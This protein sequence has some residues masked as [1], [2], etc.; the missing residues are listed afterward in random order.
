MRQ[1]RSTLDTE[2]SAF[3]RER[4]FVR[5]R[6]KREEKRIDV[7]DFVLFRQSKYL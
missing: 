4:E 1:Q 2:R 6:I 7:S 3:E 5:E